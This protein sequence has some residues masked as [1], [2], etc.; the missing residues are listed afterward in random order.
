M[1][2]SIP[3]RQATIARVLAVLVGEIRNLPPDGV[4]GWIDR[5]W[6]TAIFKRPVTGPVWFGHMGPVGDHHA[7]LTRHGGEEKA[8]LAFS[9]SSYDVLR[10]EGFDGAS[11][12][13]FGENLL[14]QGA[15]ETSV[16]IGDLVAIGGAQLRVVQ[17]RQ[18]AW[19]IARRWHDTRLPKR[20]AAE[21]RTGWYCR[22]MKPGEI[23]P[24]SNLMLL[25]RPYPHISVRRAVEI[26]YSRHRD[27]SAAQELASCPALGASWRAKLHVRFDLPDDGA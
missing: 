7:D 5:P 6:R 20:L 19:K 3:L 9:Q 25:E 27:V 22:V 4:G 18:P 2:V 1:G 13:S 26:L 24:G 14:V 17:P 16:C 12:G 21:G 15:D 10:A 11:A 8:V 23:A